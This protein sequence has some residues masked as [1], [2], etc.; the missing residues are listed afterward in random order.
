MPRMCELGYLFVS[1]GDHFVQSLPHRL[2]CI[3]WNRQ[4]SEMAGALSLEILLYSHRLVELEV[5]H[6]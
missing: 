6:V 5:V 2:L 1:L 3:L 4:D